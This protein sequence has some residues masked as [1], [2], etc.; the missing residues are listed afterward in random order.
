MSA[1]A[2]NL[3]V[4]APSSTPPAAT[5][6]WPDTVPLPAI[7]ASLQNNSATTWPRPALWATVILLGGMLGLMAWNVYGSSRWATR[8]TRLERG[9]LRTARLDLNRADR[10]QLM[11]LQGL[12]ET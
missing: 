10:V 6:A 5:P 7:P 3:G 9:A 1:A 12:G 8:P 4:A 2:P 11:Q